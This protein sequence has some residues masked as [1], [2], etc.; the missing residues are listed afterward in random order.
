MNSIFRLKTENSENKRLKDSLTQEV[1][2]L[3]GVADRR[4]AE[5]ENLHEDCKRLTDQLVAANSSK[6]DALVRIEDIE[7]KEINVKHRE[8]RLEQERELFEERL[9]NLSDDLR[10]AHDNASLN[11]RELS[12]KIAQLEGDLSHK[13]ESIRILEGREEAL[14]GDKQILQSRLDDL[15]ERLKD[16]RDSKS[17][18]EEV[19]KLQHLELLNLDT[20]W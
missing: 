19:N 13:T 4:K 20:K 1:E 2:D 9:R 16:V 17:T 5:I 7:T 11:R 6:C 18:L 14:T 12:A 3:R 15:I 8:E 10:Q